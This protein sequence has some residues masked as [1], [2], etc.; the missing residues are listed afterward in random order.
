M[1]EMIIE[2]VSAMEKNY[3]KLPKAQAASIHIAGNKGKKA[4]GEYLASA[5]IVTVKAVNPKTG[6][7]EW[8]PE[9]EWLHICGMKTPRR[10]YADSVIKGVKVSGIEKARKAKEEI[11]SKWGTDAPIAAKKAKVTKA[12]LESKVAELQAKLEALM[13]AR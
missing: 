10:V 1:N 2:K 3:A 6:N 11:L 4:D 9:N 7:A 5:F 8:R 13:A 12:E